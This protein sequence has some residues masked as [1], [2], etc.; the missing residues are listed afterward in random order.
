MLHIRADPAASTGRIH[1]AVHC[2]AMVAALLVT[3]PS[4]DVTVSVTVS[5]VDAV[6]GW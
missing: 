5:P 6:S 2:T 1:Q 3:V 4:A